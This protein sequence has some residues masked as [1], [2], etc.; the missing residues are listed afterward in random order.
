MN[1]T[2]SWNSQAQVARVF[3]NSN[4]NI[5]STSKKTKTKTKQ[6]SSE[7][8]CTQKAVCFFQLHQLHL[9]GILPLQNLYTRPLS[10]T[11]AVPS[12][13][14]IFQAKS[15]KSQILMLLFT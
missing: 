7:L 6:T 2:L 1:K 12:T 4:A 11:A 9:S 10:T 3:M 13:K 14:G 8:S 15:L 5:Q